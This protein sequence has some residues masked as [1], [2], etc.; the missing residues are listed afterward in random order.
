MFAK[1]AHTQRHAH[2]VAARLQLG[3]Q[4]GIARHRL[5]GFGVAVQHEVAGQHTQRGVELGGSVHRHRPALV[6]EFGHPA[7]GGRDADQARALARLHDQPQA[8][9]ALL[10]LVSLSV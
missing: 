9:A 6:H 8:V 4:A 5:A 1:R 2:R 7:M 3:H 10:F